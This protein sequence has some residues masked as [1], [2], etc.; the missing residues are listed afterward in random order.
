MKENQRLIIFGDIHGCINELNEL[1]NFLNI[2]AMDKLY[3][4]GDLI[5][6]GPDPAAVVKRCYEL[7]QQH[8]FSLILGNHEEKLLRYLRHI[9][10]KSGLE[11]QMKGTDEFERLL[12]GIGQQEIDFLKSAY[13]SIV[14]KEENITLLHGGI[15]AKVKFPFPETYSYLE[16]S[17]KKFKGIDLV[18]RVRYL[19]P[20]GN[21]VSLN[22][23]TA[24]DRYWAE[25]Y[26][27]SFGH[28]FFGHQPFM[29]ETPKEFNHA[30][31]LDTGCVFGGW[32]SAVVIENGKRNYVSV[33]ANK[34]YAQKY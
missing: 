20:D 14:L 19:N 11:K 10:N 8:H 22:E 33:K 21:F 25:V 24:A 17:S 2:S 1:L 3:S 5:D 7:S 31:G 16:H 30:T 23:E 6:R 13:Y 4:I 34:V 28:I 32:L 15:S 18:T 9:E 27:G 29:Q 12:A 26:D